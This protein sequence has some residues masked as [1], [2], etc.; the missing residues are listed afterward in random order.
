MPE[1]VDPNRLSKLFYV[2]LAWKSTGRL[3]ERSIPTLQVFP[4]V[5]R[6]NRVHRALYEG[7][8]PSL[9]A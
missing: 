3:F 5:R 4:G 2:T 9:I 8:S 6:F 7:I 1:L